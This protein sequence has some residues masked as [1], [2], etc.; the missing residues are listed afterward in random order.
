[1]QFSRIERTR[2]STELAP[3][4]VEPNG[5][6]GAD[7]W[8]NRGIE[9]VPGEGGGTSWVADQIHFTTDGVPDPADVLADFAAVW[10]EHVGTSA[11][12][13]DEL[14]DAIAELSEI[15]SDNATT[16]ADIGDAIAEL[17][18]IVSDL[19]GGEQ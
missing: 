3:V 4:V 19:V 6:G 2:S 10:D 14:A 8:L 5:H 16:I 11:V 7:V 1:M 15:S 18:T 9:A 12:T 17:S 13:V